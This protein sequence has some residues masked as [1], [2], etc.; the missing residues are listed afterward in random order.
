M[1]NM[2]KKVFI[3]LSA[4]LSIIAFAVLGGVI[5]YKKDE[6]E[7]VKKTLKLALIITLIFTAISAFLSIYNHIGSLCPNYYS[8]TAYD[9]YD[10]LSTIV[11]LSKIIVFAILIIKEI[12]CV[13]KIKKLN[14]GK[15]EGNLTEENSTNKEIDESLKKDKR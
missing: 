15:V 14:N 5:W 10:I 7:D 6:E 8:S 2:W 13:I 1:N 12:V 11:A 3:F 4:Y 9:F